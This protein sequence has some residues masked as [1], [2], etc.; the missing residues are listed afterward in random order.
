MTSICIDN[1]QDVPVLDWQATLPL[2]NEGEESQ[3]FTSFPI[4]SLP[5]SLRLAIDEVVQ[6]VQCPYSLAVS[7]AF[8]VLSLTISP[9]ANVQRK[10]HLTGPTN[11][12]LLTLADSGERKSTVDGFFLKGIQQFIKER[13]QVVKNRVTQFDADYQ[14]WKEEQ[15]GLKKAIREAAKAREPIEELKL[16]M[17]ELEERKP[18]PPRLTNM[19]LDDITIE[20]LKK[21]LHQYPISMIHSA[22][23]GVVF[24][25]HSTK[26]DEQLKF[27]STLNEA[28]DGKRF[29]VSRATSECFETGDIRL[30][31]AL[32]AQPEAVQNFIF[33]TGNLGRGTGFFARTLLSQPESTQGNRFNHEIPNTWPNLNRFNARIQN[34]LCTYPDHNEG[35]PIDPKLILLSPE[36]Q[37]A[38][39][40]YADDVETRL[41]VGNSLQ[42]L[43]DVGSKAADNVARLACLFHVFEYGTEKPIEFQTMQN[44]I[45]IVEW[46]VQ[47]SCRIL[48]QWSTTNDVSEA[49]Q[50]RDYLIRYCNQRGVTQVKFRA[51]QQCISPKRFRKSG[52]L[53]KIIEKLEALHIIQQFGGIIYLH[54]RLL[55]P[56]APV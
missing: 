7:S 29:R 50:V 35:E 44:A 8:A 31:V 19:L 41:L 11:L 13:N 49:V 42:D 45:D 51:L 48:G 17:R 10:P 38:W 12:F 1:T 20:G 32:M 47:E 15:A 2:D 36:A 52:L 18:K 14:V 23:A 54:P 26:K 22:E 9:L 55:H 46:Y 37:E 4:Q 21:S 43:R 40:L 3:V 24:G 25:G 28:W 6:F 16:A 53:R 56:V 34:L 27:F 5:E 33:R 39:Q 30:T